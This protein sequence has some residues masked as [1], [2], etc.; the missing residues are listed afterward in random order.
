MQTAIDYLA[1]PEPRRIAIEHLAQQLAPGRRV[2]LSTHMNADGDG[3]GSEVALA[4]LLVQR[5][6]DVRIVNPTPWPVLFDFL[7]ADD[8]KDET[9]RGP[10]ALKDV[11]VLVVSTSAT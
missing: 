6:L 4:R 10:A 8:V 9:R 2:A 3:C 7:L 5:G 11:D 1:I